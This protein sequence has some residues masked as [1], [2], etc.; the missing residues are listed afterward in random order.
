MIPSLRSAGNL[1]PPLA[2]PT[3]PPPQPDAPA[4]PTPAPQNGSCSARCSRSSTRS[5]NWTKERALPAV[6]SRTPRCGTCRR[7]Q[8][9]SGSCIS[10]TRLS[11]RLAKPRRG[12][13]VQ[14]LINRC[15]LVDCNTH[16]PVSCPVEKPSPWP[17]AR[18]ARSPGVQACEERARSVR[19]ACE[20]RARQAPACPPVGVAAG[21]CAL[22]LTVVVGLPQRDILLA[23]VVAV[24]NLLPAR[25]TR[26]QSVGGLQSRRLRPPP[27]GRGSMCPRPRHA[28]TSPRVQARE[29]LVPGLARIFSL[30]RRPQQRKDHGAGGFLHNA[31]R[32]ARTRIS[33][34]VG[35]AALPPAGRRMRV[36]LRRSH[37]ARHVL[38]VRCPTGTAQATYLRVRTRVRARIP[39]PAPAPVSALQRLRPPCRSLMPVLAAA[40]KS[41][42]PG[43]VR[44]RSLTL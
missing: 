4:P 16:T 32:P 18:A 22:K 34:Q 14:V 25:H 44:G 1:R 30:L 39:S 7:A 24:L 23:V 12:C 36:P 8:E 5:S 38:H 9:P 37:A 6:A 28:A 19:A 15:L 31:H 35:A 42:Q 43:F 40:T 20:R 13:W 26:R 10:A 21:K 33:R 3:N 2:H 41:H 17:R 29:A 27:P 11:L